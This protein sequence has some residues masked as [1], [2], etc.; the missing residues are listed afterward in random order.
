M[1]IPSLSKSLS[2]SSS[3]AD[4]G[5]LSRIPDTTFFHPGSRIRTVSIPDPGSAS[6]NLSILIPKKPKKWFLTSRKFDL[7]CSSQ[8]PD[9]DADFLP[10]PD[11]G[12]RGQK[13]TG[14]R[15][16]IRNTALFS[17]LMSLTFSK[18]NPIVFSDAIDNLPQILPPT[19]NY[20]HF[21]RHWPVFFSRV[22]TDL[23][24]IPLTNYEPIYTV[25]TH[26]SKMSSSEKICG[27]C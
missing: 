2:L 21:A 22:V 4:P 8:I 5:C 11:P 24:Q 12:S 3:V 14:S 7:G 15:I 16:R 23:S 19:I 6:K 17:L 13:G 20:W 9:P 26:Q 27:R 18:P 1:R 25:D 10:I